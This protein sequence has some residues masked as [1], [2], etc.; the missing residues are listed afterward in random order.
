MESTHLVQILLPLHDNEKKPFPPNHYTAI[1]DELTD[2]FGGVTTYSQAPAEGLWQDGSGTVTD[3]IIVMEVMIEQ[4]DPT[5]WRDFRGRL[6][7]R[8]RQ[9]QIIIRSI[10]IDLL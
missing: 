4:P 7:K 6:E 9:D 8:F 2:R 3:T 10:P 5:W 1:A